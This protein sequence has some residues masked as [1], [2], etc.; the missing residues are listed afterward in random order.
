M[1]SLRTVADIARYRLCLGCGACAY[2]C[3]TRRVSLVDIA[4]EGI[5]PRLQQGDCTDCT[6]C[7]E[8][9]PGL[10]MQRRPEDVPHGIIQ[11]LLPTFGPVLELWEGHAADPILRHEGSSGG[12]LTALAAFAVEQGQLHG[13]LHIGQDPQHPFRNVTRLSR[14]RE[15]LLAHTGSRYAPASA[16]DHLDWIENA[17]APCVFIGQPSEASALRKVRR[18][19]PAL[20]AKVGLV[21][22]FFCA[23]SP[24]M[25]GTIDLI[26]SRGI[27]P[28]DVTSIRYRGRGWP[29]HFEVRVRQHSEPVLRMTYRDSWH[30]VQASRPLATHLWPDGTG[31]D[32]DIACGDPWYHE[33]QPNAAGS[34]L[35]V[36]R[37]ENG[38]QWLRRAREAGYLHLTPA[39]PWKLTRSQENLVSKRG[40]V[41]GRIAALR[42]LGLPAPAFPGYSLFQQW[43][44]L[45]FSDQSRSTLGTLRRAFARGYRQPLD[46]DQLPTTDQYLQHLPPPTVNAVTTPAS[47]HSTS[48]HPQ[49]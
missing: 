44:R 13:V 10:G 14:S 19:R 30:V 11:E 25:R 8:V 40:A 47:V 18:H 6:A 45:S 28:R 29:G 12:A 7:L 32:A 41:W 4:S 46:L 3:P 37:T 38:R 26:R 9:C 1:R 2:I 24:S 36:V 43:R 39:E 34:S 22:S 15:D 31:E 20:D 35:V 5:R 49:S 48:S 27:D 33:P 23:G 16:C 42:T 17:P 21:L